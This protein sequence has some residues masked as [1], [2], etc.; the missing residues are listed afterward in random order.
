MDYLLRIY[1]KT[2]Q[3]VIENTVGLKIDSAD[4]ILC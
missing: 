1:G 3:T 2:N 4:Y